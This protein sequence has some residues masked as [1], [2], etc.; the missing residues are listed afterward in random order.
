MEVNIVRQLK[1]VDGLPVFA[2]RKG[3]KSRV[4]PVGEG[5]LDAVDDH[6]EYT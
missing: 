4:V 2:P 3:G 1:W 5:V 6:L